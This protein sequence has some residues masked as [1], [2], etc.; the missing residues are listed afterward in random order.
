MARYL[1]TG[2]AG[3]VGS[4]LCERLLAAGHSPLVLDDLSTGLAANLPAAA[5]LIV[6]DIQDKELVE[7][8]L[9]QVDGVFHLAAMA[10]VQRCS[11]AW[12]EYHRVNQSAWVM[13]LELAA[14][15]ARQQKRPPLPFVFASSA[16]VYGE[17]RLLPIAENAPLQPINAYGV[18]KLACEYQAYVAWLLHQIPVQVFRC[19]NIYGPRQRPDSH[20][21]GVISI[22]MRLL[23]EEKPLTLYGDGQQTRDFI[24]VKDVVDVMARAMERGIASYALHNLCTGTQTS[25]RQ[26]IEVLEI[27]T[28]Q[29]AE[30]ITEPARGDD[31]RES[32]GDATRLR[33]Q[34]GE[35][36]M[37][38]L[39]DG[40]G[41]LWASLK[42][43][44]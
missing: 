2:G 40:L 25:L 32:C 6:G 30:L 35:P 1:V 4:H 44:A 5:E 29:K 11:E 42:S 34:H 18:D 24:Y 16:A 19:F 7:H 14:S 20:Y 13:M 43:S 15:L 37:T 12:L 33:Q 10:S 38:A 39:R 31:I 41:T 3:F 23:R 17:Q 22:F 8:A 9:S 21:A 27:V 36:R 26:L 28:G